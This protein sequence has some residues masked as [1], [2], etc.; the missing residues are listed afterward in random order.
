MD[1][2][3]DLIIA[4]LEGDGASQGVAVTRLTTRGPLRHTAKGPRGRPYSAFLIV[5]A[6]L[7]LIGMGLFG[8]IDLLHVHLAAGG[9]WLRKYVLFA[10]S[11]IH[12]SSCMC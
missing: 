8:R 11:L 1:R 5:L 6:A 10:L 3:S 9:S 7:K 12:I 2:L 4:H